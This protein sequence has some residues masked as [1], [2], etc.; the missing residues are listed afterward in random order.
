[1][2]GRDYFR[3]AIIVIIM[4]AAGW[5]VQNPNFP[6]V[7]GL[8]LQG[9]LQVLLEANVSPDQAV[10]TEQ[11][12]TARQIIDQRVNALGVAEPLVVTEGDRRILV[13]LP[14]IENPDEA[15][16]LIQETALLEFV[17]TGSQPLPEGMC[18]R[19]TSH[20]GPARCELSSDTAVTATLSTP[21]PTFETVMTGASLRTAESQS[22]QFGNN[23]VS[24]DLHPD[25][26]DF[27]AD[28]TRAHQ[29]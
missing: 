14:G 17:D 3:L 13:E 7:R 5:V 25:A 8:D 23:F 29:G 1:M 18:V 6:L 9:G 28:Y 2:E 20:D 21:A 24:F 26:A 27:F 4:A 22:D 19:T 12:D 10:T 16:A 11:M 15:I